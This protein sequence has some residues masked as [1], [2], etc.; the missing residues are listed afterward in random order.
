MSMECYKYLHL[1]DGLFCGLEREVFVLEYCVVIWMPYYQ[2][3]V[4]KF[5]NVHNRFMLIGSALL[6]YL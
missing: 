5:E 4:S 6:M 1:T 2:K 3:Y